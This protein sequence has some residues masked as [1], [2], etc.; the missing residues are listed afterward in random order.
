MSAWDIIYFII[1]IVVAV[2]GIWNLA[3]RR[4]VFLSIVSL[5][6]FLVVLFTFV[7]KIGLISFV[8]IPGTTV[9]ELALYGAIPVFIVLAFFTRGSR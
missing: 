9:G 8:L 7:V 5:L 4:F 2:V 6:F 3:Q 1:G